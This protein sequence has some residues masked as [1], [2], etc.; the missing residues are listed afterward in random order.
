MSHH[1]QY[2]DLLK[3]SQ[4]R[5]RFFRSVYLQLHSFYKSRILTRYSNINGYQYDICAVIITLVSKNNF[6][7]SLMYETVS[8]KETTASS[9]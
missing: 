1:K 3:A 7:V 5:D 9:L 2:S 4:S 6:Y 8:F